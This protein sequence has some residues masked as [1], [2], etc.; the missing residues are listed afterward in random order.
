MFRTSIKDSFA[1]CSMSEWSG[2]VRSIGMDSN[3]IKILLDEQ[4][5]W[6]GEVQ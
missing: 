2:C 5:I 1:I 4:F 3:L 6:I